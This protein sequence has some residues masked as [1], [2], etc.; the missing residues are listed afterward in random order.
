MFAARRPALVAT[1]VRRSY[2]VGTGFEF[3]S[4]APSHSF[5][6]TTGV[7][8]LIPM[9][10]PWAGLLGASAL[11]AFGV[12]PRLGPLRAL[13]VALRSK[14]FLAPE[15]ESARTEDA[16]RLRALLAQVDKNK[17]AYIVVLGPR[18]VGKSTL[19]DTVLK[20]KAGVVDVDVSP[21]L[22]HDEI[23]ARVSER[24]GGRVWIGSSAGSAKRVVFFFKLCFGA[25]PTVVLRLTERSSGQT[26]CAVTGATRALAKRG[27]R[28]VIDSSSNAEVK[29]SIREHVLDMREMS[30]EVVMRDPR[31]GRAF[32]RLQ[33]AGLDEVVWQTIGGVPARLVKLADEVDS[34]R[35]S[36]LEACVKALVGRELAMAVGRVRDCP[37]DIGAKILPLFRESSSVRLSQLE[38]NG[39]AMEALAHNRALRADIFQDALVPTSPT[40]AFV[41]LH[42][43]DKAEDV[44]FRDTFSLEHLRELAGKE[45][46][47]QLN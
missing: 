34:A 10:Q 23:L 43:L 21:V 25:R 14:L 17:Q 18:G 1:A 8:A 31:F 45:T 30:R 42:G 2:S 26:F 37:E 12:L 3:A 6:G 38:R 9:W 4:G 40:V 29:G 46:K 16:S 27:Y 33:K 41:L 32:D 47:R 22:T 20:R 35:D 5:S 36:D 24:V 28:V 11:S 7:A 39:I 19:I 15:A 44:G 13:S